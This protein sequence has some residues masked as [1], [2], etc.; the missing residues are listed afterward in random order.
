MK[1][2]D[3][4]AP[5][6]SSPAPDK[7]RKEQPEARPHASIGGRAGRAD[8]RKALRI[9]KQAGKGNAPVSGDELNP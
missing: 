6:R 8:I 5:L 9:L 7:A 4:A 1:S 2:S 3:L